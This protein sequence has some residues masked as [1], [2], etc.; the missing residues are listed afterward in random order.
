MFFYVEPLY[1][2]AET[3]AF[4]EL[5][6]VIV[7]SMEKVVMEET[8]DEAVAALLDVSGAVAVAAPDEPDTDDPDAAGGQPDEPPA[9]AAPS[10]RGLP[11]GPSA[12]P[13]EIAAVAA[14]ALEHERAAGEAAQAGDWLSFG[15]EMAALA[16]SLERLAALTGQTEDAPDSGASEPAASP[17]PSP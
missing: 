14:E 11:L 10:G 5:K 12:S 4:P 16:D 9:R 2:H 1:L 6:R 8:L 17:T 7:A 3:S 15:E 13:E